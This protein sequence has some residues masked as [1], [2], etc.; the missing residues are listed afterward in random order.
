MIQVTAAFHHYQRRNPTGTI[1]LLRSALGRLDQYPDSFAGVAV[2]SLRGEIRSW[3]NALEA[4]SRPGPPPPLPII[5]L[6]GKSRQAN[7]RHPV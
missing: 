1:S 6:A 7:R 5:K 2:A 3:L 4:L